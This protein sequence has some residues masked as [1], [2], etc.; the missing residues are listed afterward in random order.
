[1]INKSNCDQ[2]GFQFSYRVVERGKCELV[3]NEEKKNANSKFLCVP[4]TFNEN[5][6]IKI[7]K[8]A[9]HQMNFVNIVLPDT[10]EF[11]DSFAFKDCVHLEEIRIPPKVAK[12]EPHT[13]ENC[14][15]L[16]RVDVRNND[17]KVDDKAFVG[18]GNIETVYYTDFG[19]ISHKKAVMKEINS[20]FDQKTGKLTITGT[21]KIES[22][23]IYG[24]FS[25]IAISMEINGPSEIGY[26]AI[27][28][29]NGNYGKLKYLEIGESVTKFAS[30]AIYNIENLEVIKFNGATVSRHFESYSLSIRSNKNLQLYYCSS[31]G[32]TYL[33]TYGNDIIEGAITISVPSNYFSQQDTQ[34]TKNFLMRE[35]KYTDVNTIITS[36]NMGNYSYSG[37]NLTIFDIEITKDKI[38]STSKKVQ[39][40][41]NSC[42]LQNIMNV[43]ITSVKTISVG[44]FQN[45]VSLKTIVFNSA[46]KLTTIE[47]NTFWGCRSLISYPTMNSIKEI[48]G[49]AF[50][51]CSSLRDFRFPSSLEKIG[52][53]AFIN[54]SSLQVMV[55]LSNENFNTLGSSA[56]EGCN[57]ITGI[58]LGKSVAVTNIGSKAFKGCNSL[59]TI[60]LSESVINI[61]E[62]AFEN[63][64]SIT[65]I[66]I[67]KNVKNIYPKAF[68]GCTNLST[69]KACTSTNPRKD[70]TS[71]SFKNC[72]IERV[73][74]PI[75]YN[76]NTGFCE[77]KSSYLTH[78]SKVQTINNVIFSFI[79][80]ELVINVTPGTTGNNISST[81]V[82]SFINSIDN[83]CLPK[84][85]N[86]KEAV[87]SLKIGE[88][89]ETIGVDTFVGFKWITNELILPSTIRD[90]NSNSFNGCSGITGG[91]KFNSH[92]M[93]QITSN[94][95]MGCSNITKVFISQNIVRIE[96]RAFLDCSSLN[97]IIYC[98]TSDPGALSVDRMFPDTFQ[99]R[100]LF[101][102]SNYNSGA[103]CRIGVINRNANV[104]YYTNGG[105]IIAYTI[106]GK[107]LTISPSQNGKN[108]T[109]KDVRD[110]CS[111]NERCIS[112]GGY[113][114]LESVTFDDGIEYISESSFEGCISL[115]AIKKIPNSL[116]RIEENAF[117]NCTKLNC[118][119]SFKENME[120]LGQNSFKYCT[121][122]VG[123][124]KI[125]SRRLTTF[126]TS[127]FEGCSMLSNVTISTSITSIKY[128]AFRLCRSL[129]G[130]I[131]LSHESF[132]LLGDYVFDGC[133][134]ITGIKLGKNLINTGFAICRGC[135]SLKYIDLTDGVRNILT[136]A[137]ENCVSIEEVN[138]PNSVNFIYPNAFNGCTKLKTIKTCGKRNPRYNSTSIS[139]N[140]CQIEK[141]IIMPG[142][143]IKT[144]FCELDQSLLTNVSLNSTTDDGIN[145]LIVASSLTISGVSSAVVS[146]AM[147]EKYI[148]SYINPCLPMS[149]KESI[150]TLIIN[151]GIKNIG[152]NAFINFSNIDNQLIFPN[153]IETIEGGAFEGCSSIPG[154]VDL[155][156]TKIDKISMRSFRGCSNITQ[157]LISNSVQSIEAYAFDGCTSLKNITIPTSLATI[158]N[159]AFQNCSSLTG[160]ID[161][162]HDVLATI[163]QSVFENCISLTGIKFGSNVADS[164]YYTCRGCTNLVNVEFKEGIKHIL[165]SAFESCASIEEVSFPKSIINIYP[166]A[167]NGC[168]KLR[169]IKSCIQVNPRLAQSISFERCPNLDKV[170][171]P[172]DYNISSGFCELNS[173]LLTNISKTESTDGIKFT[174]IGSVLEI[175]GAK[176]SILTSDMVN[177]HVNS[178]NNPCLSSNKKESIDSLKIGE[179]IK[180]I[181]D[182]AFTNF[183]NIGKELVLP[184]SLEKIGEGAFEGCLGIQKVTFKANQNMIT[185]NDRSF[186]GCIGLTDVV[187]PEKLTNIG[188]S[189][190]EGTG[191]INI[192][193]PLSLVTIKQ[194]AFKSC[195]N[196]VIATMK[197]TYELNSL[198][199]IENE[200]FANCK[201]LNSFNLGHV[202]EKIGNYSFSNTSIKI[203]E[204]PSTLAEIGEG[205]FENCKVEQIKI[206]SSVTKIFPR[207]FKSNALLYSVEY[208]GVSD[209]A[210]TDSSQFEDCLKLNDTKVPLTYKDHQFCEKKI[211]MSL[212]PGYCNIET[213]MFSF[214]SSFSVSSEF[215]GTLQF[216]NSEKFMK[217]SE[218][219][220]SENFKSTSSFVKTNLFSKTTGFEQSNGFTSSSK[221]SGSNDFSSSYIFS[222]SPVFDRPSTHSQSDSFTK[223]VKFTQTS[224]FSK[225]QIL[226]KIAKPTKTKE[227]SNSF[228]FT[229][230]KTSKFEETSISHKVSNTKENVTRS[231]TKS[232]TSLIDKTQQQSSSY[233]EH[234]SEENPVEDNAALKNV[235]GVKTGIV[236]GIVVGI[237]IA[238]LIILI[239]IYLL[240]TRKH[241]ES[242]DDINDTAEMETSYTTEAT[243]EAELWT[244]FNTMTQDHALFG[245]GEQM[246]TN[247]M[248]I[249]NFEEMF[250]F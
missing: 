242:G 133:S 101:V 52:Q 114:K 91:I 166:G 80:T 193:L 231:L 156:K 139:F 192:D 117:F 145:F 32:P 187:F 65:E 195:K 83:P 5:K 229:A 4:D 204:L 174:F 169:K 183:T 12:I 60:E 150:K 87:K 140:G 107:Y 69:I 23:S 233:L 143:D 249:E 71:I 123:P 137:F 89:I 113:D 189:A 216:K 228:H 171:V 88:G 205:A 73:I 43:N 46:I 61:L 102:V 180:N 122:L 215:G 84:Y 3:Q 76:I 19:K 159:L 30:Y 2:D 92:Y 236:V 81:M 206:P 47:A 70:Q 106:I 44:A 62:S 55:D 37:N 124:I 9:F 144:G 148:N 202:L 130:V 21:G 153:S 220:S 134:S 170:I 225:S 24:Q 248:F 7:G 119:I 78:T 11:I 42:G 121:S 227:I 241:N 109:K 26:N 208:C 85:A 138:I 120:Y 240:I 36:D 200:A 157:V 244:E 111:M 94:S 131:D 160:T 41:C 152:V 95:F 27:N 165:T 45:C 22:N 59:N 40:K 221:F 178:Y 250:V 141:V 6:V 136:N 247:E 129:T 217:S 127:V 53:L 177:I 82:A 218:F 246:N 16:R 28:G 203:L 209:P 235:K 191:L 199:I 211:N 116:K 49:S 31:I 224:E 74:V 184:G 56:F 175:S 179:G 75:D 214:S 207:A 243:E 110:F 155:T 38:N 232:V 167:F 25:S 146:S 161:L 67:T 219:S 57:K 20:G 212:D 104:N 17:V 201:S 181:G 239:V 79:G 196:L 99:S 182:N 194:A 66:V 14:F 39:N 103:F 128:C 118:Q 48:K 151:D 186:K 238:I 64:I 54:C 63:C 188:V 226:S 197:T 97:E 100:G 210:V 18:C 86:K 147:V 185:I 234:S 237:I 68:D 168:T 158:G 8:Y 154:R 50:N 13:F 163:G 125:D 51:G 142:Y 96:D 29:G 115:A 213:I 112:C 105:Q 135:S 176:D 132:N 33:K 35:V 15:S 93:T 108:V 230:S 223:T 10:I 1:M 164:G 126:E 222:K 245:D 34:S 98:G 162:S 172:Q 198:K 90:I 173:K 77:I 72:P 58:K 190:F 149:K